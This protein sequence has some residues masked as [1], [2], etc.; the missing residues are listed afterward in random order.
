M[1][2]SRLL[3]AALLMALAVPITALGD[4]SDAVSYQ[5]VLTLNGVI[6][7][8]GP[9][10]ITFA[11]YDDPTAGNA[12]FTQTLPVQVK[13]GLYNVILSDPSLQTAFDVGNRYMQLTIQPGPGIPSAIP[14]LPR[15]QITSAPYAL[16]ATR[17]KIVDAE[18][19]QSLSFQNQWSNYFTA[20]NGPA[21][22]YR[23][24]GSVVH[25]RG[26]IKSGTIGNPL[27]ANIQLFTALPIGYRPQYT[28][29]LTATGCCIPTQSPDQHFQATLEIGSDGVLKLRH[30]PAATAPAEVWISMAGVS[31]RVD[32]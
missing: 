24:P 20:G 15:H 9:Y 8:D 6:V 29:I 2:E 32:Q 27:A 28:L 26:L 23:D 10:N 1:A 19:W 18:P 17:A 14:M 13:D 4:V 3:I 7:P 31:Y 21:G 11:I 22:Y 16:R 12:V 25:F 5:G 30:I